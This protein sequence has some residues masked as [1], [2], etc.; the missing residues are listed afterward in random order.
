MGLGV[1]KC[2]ECNVA[3]DK[4]PLS[5]GNVLFYYIRKREKERSTFLNPVLSSLTQ[6]AG[7]TSCFLKVGKHHHATSFCQWH[8]PF[9]VQS[10]Q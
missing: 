2:C 10:D 3:R 4:N 8:L 6:V 7:F 9:S 1:K 5:V